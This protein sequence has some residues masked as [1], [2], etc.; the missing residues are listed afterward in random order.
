VVIIV[1]LQ[2]GVIQPLNKGKHDILVEVTSCHYVH[3]IPWTRMARHNNLEPP[4][5]EYNNVQGIFNFVNT[6]FLGMGNVPRNK[7]LD[8]DGESLK[9]YMLALDYIG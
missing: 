2:T 5:Y 7:Q 4:M 8:N 3:V 1:R 6:V 9:A